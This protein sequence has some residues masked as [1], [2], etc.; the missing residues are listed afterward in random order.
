MIMY[1]YKTLGLFLNIVI[2]KYNNILVETYIYIIYL[3]SHS[4]YP[5]YTQ[6]SFIDI[7]IK[8]FFIDFIVCY[9]HRTSSCNSF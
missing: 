2:C 7:I 8:Q 4:Y 9:R 5:I 3:I 6:Y 1:V